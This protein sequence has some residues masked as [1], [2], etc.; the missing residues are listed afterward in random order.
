MIVYKQILSWNI[1]YLME[2]SSA[3]SLLSVAQSADITL[4]Q[5]GLELLHHHCNILTRQSSLEGWSFL[6][7]W[8]WSC[9]IWRCV[10]KWCHLAEDF[11]S[12]CTKSLK[13][14]SSVLPEKVNIT[15]QQ[16][17]GNLKY[18][19]GCSTTVCCQIYRIPVIIRYANTQLLYLSFCKL[20]TL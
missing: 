18:V 6:I 4:A 10:P 8:R 11:H 2:I 20:C 15:G 7:F 14:T 17:N 5:D 16:F 13:S 3:I 19:H 9:G 1:P 12:T